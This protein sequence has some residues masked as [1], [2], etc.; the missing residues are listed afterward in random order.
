VT[1]YKLITT[2]SVDESILE[3]SIQKAK[4]NYIML[5]ENVRRAHCCLS[6]WYH[7]RGA[8]FLSASIDSRVCGV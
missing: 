6:W 4:L 1:V 8:R 7:L 3:R 5:G 2:D